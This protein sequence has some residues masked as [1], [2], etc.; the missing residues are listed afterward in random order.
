M[1]PPFSSEKPRFQIW[2]Q[3]KHPVKP[4]MKKKQFKSSMLSLVLIFCSTL[5]SLFLISGF[6]I[7]TL[8]S[9]SIEASLT[10]LE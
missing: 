10:D 1:N 8:I 4:E 9:G 3:F 2:I 5:E 7:A 6:L